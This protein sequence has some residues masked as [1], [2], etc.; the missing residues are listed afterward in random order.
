MIKCYICNVKCC[1]YAKSIH[2]DRLCRNQIFL[3]QGQRDK[4][5]CGAADQW[6]QHRS[7]LPE[8]LW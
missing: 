7:D 8:T 1:D 5:C 6:Q 4:G 3:R 2:Y